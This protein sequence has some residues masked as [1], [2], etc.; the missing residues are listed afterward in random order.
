MM[1]RKLHYKTRLAWELSFAN[2][3]QTPTYEEL[4]TYL[5]GV[6]RSY[7]A[8]ELN[9][10]SNANRGAKSNDVVK[11]QQQFP[12]RQGRINMHTHAVTAGEAVKGCLLCNGANGLYRYSQ[13]IGRTVAERREFVE[14]SRICFNCI[15]TTR[16]NSRNCP[17]KGM[18]SSPSHHV[19]FGHR[20]SVQ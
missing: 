12:L 19:A 2:G 6:L 13:F 3:K 7:Q 16:H 15:A 10:E 14:A 11:H 18:S 5:R 9:N 1:A 17:S 4:N 20:F 8:A